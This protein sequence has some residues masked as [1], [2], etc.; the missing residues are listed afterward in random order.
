MRLLKSFFMAT[1]LVFSNVSLAH[2]DHGPSRVEA[3]HGGAMRSLETI[4]LEMVH[5]ND[6]VKIYLYSKDMKPKAVKD[7]PMTATLTLPKEKSLAFVLKDMGN[8][9][10]GKYIGK[11]THRYSI[12]LEIKQGGHKDKIEY[13]IERKK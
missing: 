8:H 12:H 9:W 5:L 10:E 4:H 13:T 1:T 6:D 2:E 7:I 3:P 11:D